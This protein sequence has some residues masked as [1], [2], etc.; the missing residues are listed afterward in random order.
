MGIIYVASLWQFSGNCQVQLQWVVAKTLCPL[1]AAASKVNEF[2]KGVSWFFFL[3]AHHNL[4][5]WFD[6]SSRYI[7]LTYSSGD[8]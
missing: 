5:L 3:G 1:P 7:V 4:D 8:F 2:K 6:S